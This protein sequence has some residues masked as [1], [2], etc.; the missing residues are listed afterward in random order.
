MECLYSTLGVSPNAK[1]E[2]IKKAYLNAM[3]KYRK[4]ESE[5][6]TQKVQQA[7]EVLSDS[8]ERS[9]YD[10]NRDE[11]LKINLAPSTQSLLDLTPYFLETCFDSLEDFYVVYSK[12][13]NNIN[14][15]DKIFFGTNR[16]KYPSFGDYSSSKEVWNKFY[17]FF[18]NYSSALAF[19][20][21]RKQ[22]PGSIERLK[23]TPSQM[24]IKRNE[25]VKALAQYIRSK[26]HRCIRRRFRRIS[27]INLSDKLSPKS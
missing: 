18:E 6:R 5:E 10:I 4:G 26:D 1:A 24:R 14:L 3:S 9:W 7:Y 8:H 27:L 17:H 16:L 11:I 12:V 13:F 25:T 19:Q 2:D 20:W 15:E 23:S 21:L 22:N